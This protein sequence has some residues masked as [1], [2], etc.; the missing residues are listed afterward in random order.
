[1]NV[2]QRQAVAD[3]LQ[4]KQTDLGCESAC[5]LLPA[6]STI[7]IFLLFSPKAVTNFSVTRRVEG[8]VNLAHNGMRNFRSSYHAGSQTPR[9]KPRL[10]RDTCCRIQVVSTCCRQRVSCIGDKIVASLSLVCCW[11]QRDNSRPRHKWIVI[12]S[13]RYSPHVSRT[14]NYT[15]LPL[16][17]AIH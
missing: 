3:P 9:L 7:A 4:T 10:H 16:S 6:T 2:E 13:P 15:D 1:M 12:M 8:W 17:M 5:R 14:S 11:I